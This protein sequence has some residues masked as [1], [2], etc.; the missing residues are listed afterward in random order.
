[1]SPLKYMNDGV[2]RVK[3]VQWLVKRTGCERRTEVKDTARS[4]GTSRIHSYSKRLVALMSEAKR[5][6]LHFSIKKTLFAW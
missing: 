5:L 6:D 3:P 4:C 1:M 2:N